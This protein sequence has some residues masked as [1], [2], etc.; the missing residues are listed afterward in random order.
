MQHDYTV[1][2]HPYGQEPGR[3]IVQISPST[4][5]GYFEHKDGSEGGGLWFELDF[6]NQKDLILTDYDGV[7]CLPRQVISALRAHGVTVDPIF[8]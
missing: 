7:Y 1:T 8:E 6:D 2:L 3:G 4:H 5:Y